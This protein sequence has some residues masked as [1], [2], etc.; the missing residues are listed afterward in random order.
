MKKIIPTLLL[1][2]SMLALSSCGGSGINYKSTTQDVGERTTASYDSYKKITTIRGPEVDIS[3]ALI[4]NL[5]GSNYYFIRAYKYKS[6][7]EH[8]LL[9]VS[10][11]HRAD[12]YS[13]VQDYKDYH[14]ATDIEGK[15]LKFVRIDTDFDISCY[16]Y[17][18]TKYY[19]EDFGIWL[20]RDYMERE[21]QDKINIKVYSKRGGDF[22]INISPNYINAILDKVDAS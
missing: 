8:Y 17:G 11:R 19:R 3:G 16:S 14:G 9:Y 1:I 22:I 6:G 7:E 15:E 20:S 5:S 10:K 13:G 12:K 2:F 21:L 4:T 18:C